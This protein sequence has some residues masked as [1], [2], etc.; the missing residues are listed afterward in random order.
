MAETRVSGNAWVYD[1]AWVYGN[2]R[3]SGNAWVYDTRHVLVIGPVGSRDDFTTF[4]KTACGVSVRCGCFC[5]GIE[6]FLNSVETTHG[7]SRYGK[8]YR[9]A[10]EMAKIQILGE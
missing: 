5:G 6:D 7:E 2:A 9:L 4:F 8:V 1:N 3:V 10:A